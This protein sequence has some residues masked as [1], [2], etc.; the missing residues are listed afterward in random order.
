MILSSKIRAK[1]NKCLPLVVVVFISCFFSSRFS[2]CR[3][4]IRNPHVSYI[5]FTK[6]NDNHG[7]EA[8]E[9]KY[10]GRYSLINQGLKL[11][12]CEKYYVDVL[13]VTLPNRLHVSHGSSNSFTCDH[14]FPCMPVSPACSTQHCHRNH[15]VCRQ[16]VARVT[17]PA[18][19][20]H[21]GL[22]P[23]IHQARSVAYPP[24]FNFPA[25]ACPRF[26]A[27]YGPSS[28]YI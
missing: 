21:C 7:R 18:F 13:N 11:F 28:P 20:T 10:W 8:S 4:N 5:N 2:V 12:L 14:H 24:R 22:R 3:D 17:S 27:H 1:C 6:Q 26:M 25:S 19:Y 9:I 15:I 23:V 16:A